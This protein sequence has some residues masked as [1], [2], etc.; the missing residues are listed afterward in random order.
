MRGESIRWGSLFGAG[1]IYAGASCTEGAIHYPLN[2]KELEAMTGLGFSGFPA[3]REKRGGNAF[4][5]TSSASA[6][7]GLKSIFVDSQALDFTLES[8]ISDAQFGRSS[9]WS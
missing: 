8:R 9:C 3:G 5:A 6:Y 1:L 7:L 4:K 2:T